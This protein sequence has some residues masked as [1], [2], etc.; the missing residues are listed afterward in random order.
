M[1]KSSTPT[2]PPQSAPAKN[3]FK[4]GFGT[5]STVA[6]LLTEI[7]FS[8]TREQ[9]EREEAQAIEAMGEFAKKEMA[10]LKAQSLRVCGEDL[11]SRIREFDDRTAAITKAILDMAQTEGWPI[12]DSNGFPKTTLQRHG[13]IKVSLV[14][15]WFAE[16]RAPLHAKYAQALDNALQDASEKEAQ[17]VRSSKLTLK[18]GEIAKVFSFLTNLQKAMSNV[19]KHQWLLPARVTRGRPR[20][21]ATWCPLEMAEAIRARKG[22]EQELRWAFANEHLLLP[23][24]EAWQEKLKDRNAFGR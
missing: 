4:D 3:R 16:G 5:V 14:R 13:L 22:Y 17:Q 8:A 1:P 9:I 10:Y 19:K 18:T 12:T 24:R 15:D 20:H 21:A 11:T 2:S 7:T 23:W 6:T